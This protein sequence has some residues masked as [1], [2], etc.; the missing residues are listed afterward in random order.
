[1]R[2]WK[3]GAKLPSGLLSSS[4]TNWFS[5]HVQQMLSNLQVMSQEQFNKPPGVHSTGLSTSLLCWTRHIRGVTVSIYALLV[6][7]YDIQA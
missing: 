3:P 7:M 6:W 5:V 4:G 2:R 1:M